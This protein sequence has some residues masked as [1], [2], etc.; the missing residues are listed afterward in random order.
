MKPFYDNDNEK[1]TFNL[2]CAVNNIL[3]T[4]TY[5]A[6]KLNETYQNS[7]KM[8]IHSEDTLRKVL[9]LEN[10]TLTD[11]TASE[12]NNAN[13]VMCWSYHNNTH[14]FWCFRRVFGDW[15][16]M[17]P[18]G[19]DK[20][21]W[22]DVKQRWT[23]LHAH[24]S[25]NVAFVEGD[26]KNTE[27]VPIPEK[28]QP[29]R[30]P[31]VPEVI[32]L[33]ENQPP[34]SPPLEPAS[35]PLEPTS[36]PPP[37]PT[38]PP[39]KRKRK[40]CR[41]QR[42]QSEPKNLGVFDFPEDDD[43]SKPRK[44]R[45]KG[46][47]TTQTS[48]RRKLTGSFGVER[49]SVMILH[50]QGKDFFLQPAKANH[51]N[52]TK[53]KTQVFYGTKRGPSLVDTWRVIT[54]RS[55]KLFSKSVIY[56]P[57]DLDDTVLVQ[58]KTDAKDA[59][60]LRIG[61]VEAIS[62]Q[63]VGV[64]FYGRSQKFGK[65][66]VSVDLSK[67]KASKMGNVFIGGVIRCPDEFL[68]K[69]QRL[70]LKRDS[71][72]GVRP[73]NPF[74][75]KWTRVFDEQDQCW[76]RAQVFEAKKTGFK[77]KYEDDESIFITLEETKRDKFQF[78]DKETQHLFSTY[79]NRTLFNNDN[80]CPV[81]NTRFSMNL[82]LK[83][84]DNHPSHWHLTALSQH[85]SFKFGD[86]YKSA[87]EDIGAK[88]LRYSGHKLIC[89]LDLDTNLSLNNVMPYALV[90]P[91]FHYVQRP[92]GPDLEACPEARKEPNLI[93]FAY[94]KKK[95]GWV[96]GRICDFNADKGK[97]QVDFGEK[98]MEWINLLSPKY[99][100][101]YQPA[102]KVRTK[103]ESVVRRSVSREFRSLSR[104][105]KKSDSEEEEMEEDSSEVESE[106]EM[107]EEPEGAEQETEEERLKKLNEIL[108]TLQKIKWAG[109][110][111][112]SRRTR[113]KLKSLYGPPGIWEAHKWCLYCGSRFS[114]TW[115]QHEKNKLLCDVH[116]AKK[117]ELGIPE[118]LPSKLPLKTNMNT[119]MDYLEI[120]LSEECQKKQ[121]LE[122]EK[123][124]ELEKA[125]EAKLSPTKKTEP[126]A[127]IRLVDD[128]SP[129]EETK[130]ET[131]SGE[132]EGI[133]EVDRICARRF[134]DGCVQYL[135]SWKGYGDDSN[136]WEPIENLSSCSDA[137]R[138]F[139]ANARS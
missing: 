1:A 81:S 87:F 70:R 58:V 92:R 12:V 89:K 25:T 67:T 10:L 110:P 129:K 35:P 123:E 36:P 73:R 101:V 31:S 96:A 74:L 131:E 40:T 19:C 62:L 46:Q 121:Q 94:I 27:L 13:A 42:P 105:T 119:E 6:E 16:L 128:N 48:K 85:D 32:T 108:K 86:T 65:T 117:E 137:I 88:N 130:S 134:S 100:V 112:K 132:G 66:H 22:S 5:T 122:N 20:L 69:I 17:R 47:E 125:E 3:Q 68:Q 95:R 82:E 59:W 56:D 72:R 34:A 51:L 37:S 63:N 115:H 120:M 111:A 28:V 75:G 93:I 41:Q 91:G 15:F 107:S 24:D 57:I 23:A 45:K 124:M 114:S 106:E 97:S 138:N 99:H 30:S 11:Y 7:D 43:T 55:P 79:K 126:P 64:K 53:G 127:I 116:H 83:F 102:G 78:E 103:S 8:Q 52:V 4:R 33:E 38:S 9:T 18:T 71:S 98:E 136:T 80:E 50:Q 61:I 84:I 21:E 39:A 139:N 44:K 90:Q 104:E 54:E 2:H 133:F 135:V 49:N 26:L 113:L 14:C 60:W 77:M 109:I 76:Y 29:A 118:K